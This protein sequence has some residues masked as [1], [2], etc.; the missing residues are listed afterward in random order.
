MPR[1]HDDLAPALRPHD[2]CAGARNLLEHCI[3]IAHG[4]SLLIVAEPPSY[5]HYDPAMVE[6]VAGEARAAGARVS[7]RF[8][9]PAAGPEDV[10]AVLLAAIAS[11]DHTLFLNR[12]GDQLRFVKLP[13]E[14]TK[15]ISYALDMSYLG[16]G[17]AVARHDRMERIRTLIV[18]HIASA[19]RYSIRCPLGTD[20]EMEA[21]DALQPLRESSGFTVRNFPVMIVPPVPA[22]R[23]N[24]RLVL[25]HALTS[26][27]VHVYEDSIFGLPAPVTLVL[28]DGIVRSVEGDGE[29]VSRVA[30]QFDRVDRLFGGAGRRVGSWHAGINPFTFFTRPALSDIERWSG[31]AFGS[32][33]YAHFHLCGAAPGD[34]CGQLFDATIRFDGEAIWQDGRLSALQWPQIAALG[35]ELGPP[36]D[37][38]SLR[39][40]IG[41]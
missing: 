23:L 21:G 29:L 30:A 20:L 15:S 10:P 27:G 8:V 6:F 35:A 32:P 9:A 5:H 14:G 39:P 25:R 3:G 41:V 16:A 2:A 36:V 19:R 37:A 34:I 28:E 26:T 4:E 1:G 24:G 17:F 12:I 18:E 11:A 7:V 40:P 22:V 33:R 31:V 13:G 38:L